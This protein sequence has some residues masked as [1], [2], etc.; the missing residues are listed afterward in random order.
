M[1][2]ILIGVFGAG[3]AVVD[4]LLFVYLIDSFQASKLLCGLTVGMTVLF[5][6]P[7]FYY[8]KSIL[9]TMG[10]Q[11]MMAIAMVAFLIR[12]FGYAI[13]TKETLNY[14]LLLELLHGLTFAMMWTATVSIVS[15]IS[16]AG[17]KTATMTIVQALWP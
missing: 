6:L 11:V 3:F 12:M 2:L 14:I 7:I 15:K 1:L 8:G 17:W 16:P 5:E 4:R 9:K 13:L 10:P